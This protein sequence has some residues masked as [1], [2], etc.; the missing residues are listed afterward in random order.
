MGEMAD[1]INQDDPEEDRDQ[2]IDHRETAMETIEDLRKRLRRTSLEVDGGRGLFETLE[3]IK[4]ENARASGTQAVASLILEMACC[5]LDLCADAFEA[6]NHASEVLR[7]RPCGC[8]AAAKSVR[9]V[10]TR[11]REQVKT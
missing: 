11:W 5:E 1:W 6:C 7:T 9:A 4:G 3:R 10:I 8:G 2:W